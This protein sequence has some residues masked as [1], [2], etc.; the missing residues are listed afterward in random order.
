MHT[1]VS[2]PVDMCHYIYIYM[3][4]YAGSGD[5]WTTAIGLV[6]P[7]VRYSLMHADTTARSTR[8]PLRRSLAVPSYSEAFYRDNDWNFIKCVATWFKTR[9]YS[10]TYGK[11]AQESCHLPGVRMCCRPLVAYD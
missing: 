4:L 7:T 5:W 10:N 11:I 2:V 8:N 1:M 9:L 3:F 6:W